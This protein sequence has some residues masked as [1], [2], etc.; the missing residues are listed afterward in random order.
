MDNCLAGGVSEP[1]PLST[2][3]RILV[4]VKRAPNLVWP[5]RYELAFMAL[6]I[7]LVVNAHWELAMISFL[8]WRAGRFLKP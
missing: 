6:E 3:G 7:G 5:Y 8:A 2:F 1:K 4:P